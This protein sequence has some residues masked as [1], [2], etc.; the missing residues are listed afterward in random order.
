[1]K[2]L[3]TSLSGQF[4]PVTAAKGIIKNIIP[5]QMMVVIEKTWFHRK[6]LIVDQHQVM[7]QNCP[8]NTNLYSIY[9]NKFFGHSSTIF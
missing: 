8:Q 5:N 4:S 7:G 2:N 6:I 3:P 9:G 1:M